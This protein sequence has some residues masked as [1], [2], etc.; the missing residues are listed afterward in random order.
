MS[1]IITIFGVATSHFQVEYGLCDIQGN[2]FNSLG[3]K[4]FLALQPLPPEQ[5]AR[6]QHRYNVLE[7]F[8]FASWESE[9]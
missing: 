5:V 2:T 1:I 4:P 8:F 7:M 3:G 9:R 6:R